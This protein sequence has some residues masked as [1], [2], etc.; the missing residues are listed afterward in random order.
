[1]SAGGRIFEFLYNGKRKK[2]S[3]LKDRSKLAGI[4]SIVKIKLRPTCF[5]RRVVYTKR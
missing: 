1:M 4:R 5:Y 3:L 2:D